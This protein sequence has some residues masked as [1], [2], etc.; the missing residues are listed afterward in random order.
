MRNILRAICPNKTAGGAC[1]PADREL[2][3]PSGGWR[4]VGRAAFTLPEILI[5]VSIFSVVALV[6]ATLYIQSFRTSRD[7]NYKRRIFEDARFVLQRIA[8]EIRNG[9]VDYDEYYNQY[10]VIPTKKQ[11]PGLALGNLASRANNYGQHFGLY[12]SAFFNPG[13]SN[14]PNVQELLGF[15]CNT[16][17]EG[18]NKRTC[19]PLRNT[20]DLNTGANPFPGKTRGAADKADENAFCATVRHSLSADLQNLGYLPDS[21]NTATCKNSLPADNAEIAHPE[22]YLISPDG[23]IK[24]ILARELVGIKNQGL[25]DEKRFYALSILRLK[26]VDL[27]NDNIPDNFICADDFTC[28][29]TDVVTGAPQK[30]NS[31]CTGSPDDTVP[32]QLPR[33]RANEL[34]KNNDTCDTREKGFAYDFV[35]ISPLSANIADLK[36]YITPS[37][38][39]YYAFDE[40]SEQVQPA[41]TIIMT[42]EPNPLFSSAA[43]EDFSPITLV[44]TVSSAPY[45]PIP[46]PVA[47]YD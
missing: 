2:E 45:K 23:K 42:I 4:N 38:D 22:L 19:V 32:G 10:V 28:V 20:L 36:F 30:P 12:Y 24:T 46:A 35:P 29:G 44:Q 33:S 43:V 9:A 6:T 40:D 26:S 21:A 17:A 37:E 7:A 11:N 27:N 18:R 47:A 5:A 25:S 31:F 15:A 41:M 13:R 1:F 16:A 8:E 39:P 34:E 3:S 14:N